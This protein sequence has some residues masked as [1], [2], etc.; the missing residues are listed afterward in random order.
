MPKIT[1]GSFLGFYRY[2]LG[3]C[4][5]NTVLN[6][7]NS[8]AK[9]KC[10]DASFAVESVFFGFIS[11]CKSA[12]DLEKFAKDYATKKGRSLKGCRRTI[13]DLLDEERTCEA[14]NYAL[15][16]MFYE[17]K[18]KRI[19]K[20]SWFL[21]LSIAYVD[22]VYLHSMRKKHENCK[23][24]L[25]K[26]HNKGKKN[27]WTE[28]YHL[29]VAISLCTEIGPI[30]IGFGLAEADALPSNFREMAEERQKQEGEK[31]VTKKLLKAM[32]KHFG[33]KLPFDL[34]G[35]DSLYPDAPH[36]ELVESLGA[37]SISV[38]KQDNRILKKE[39]ISIF[40]GQ[41]LGL[42]QVFLDEW[43]D[44][45]ANKGRVFS[46]KTVK[47][48]D[49]NRKGDQK[50]VYINQTVRQEISGKQTINSYMS[51]CAI[52]HENLP[53]ILENMRFY[54]WSHQENGVFN[55]LTNTW[56]LL[57]HPFYH[58]SN[59]MFSVFLIMFLC[60]GAFNLYAYK[61]L[62]RAGREFVDTMKT[63]FKRMYSTFF[64]MRKNLKYAFPIGKD[65]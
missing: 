14:L 27:E 41:D 49:T 40:E 2:S 11:D 26:T 43:K 31:S 33:G 59:A 47:L 19:H 37:I 25:A 60:L 35:A 16:N 10:Y 22:G 23:Y 38:F 20:P 39:A 65:P 55:G 56:G 58:K 52:S 34:L 5:L 32:A 13:K 42:N 61:N 30:P 46:S 50:E 51:S 53:R 15:F 48:R 3:K 6:T 44:D 7:L 57:K 21:G 12:N 8:R 18:R 17:C 28:Y 24:C 45:P 9:G 4:G 1:H 62:K 64:S 54:R 29:G 36:T 63:F